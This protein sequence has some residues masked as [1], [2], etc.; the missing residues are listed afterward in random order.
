M[1]ERLQNGAHGVDFNL[2]QTAGAALA[3]G[4]VGLEQVEVG[5]AV[6]LEQMAGRAMP[7][8]AVVGLRFFTQQGLCQAAGKFG[9][10][11]VFAAG[12][13]P[14]V[15]LLLPVFGK[16]PPCVAVPGINHVSGCLKGLVARANLVGRRN[17]VRIDAPLVFLSQTDQAAQAGHIGVDVQPLAVALRFPQG[18]G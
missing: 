18:F 16:L 2:L 7:A 17:F 3:L 15:G 10:A 13:Q 1:G 5:M 4:L 9:F 12:E 8:G 14:G 11:G 6:L